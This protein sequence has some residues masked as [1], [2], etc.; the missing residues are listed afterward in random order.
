MLGVFGRVAGAL[1][2]FKWGWGPDGGFVSFVSH[3]SGIVCRFWRPNGFSKQ[4]C[5]RSIPLMIF[6][7]ID[8]IGHHPGPLAFWSE[9]QECG[10]IYTSQ[11]NHFSAWSFIPLF[12][13][14]A[15]F[16]CFTDPFLAHPWIFFSIIVSLATETDVQW[17]EHQTLK[18]GGKIQV[19]T[20][21]SN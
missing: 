11:I 9:T 5:G 12:Y 4:A 21:N 7:A 1:L 19:Q 2:E 13:S 16:L 3:R 18:C 14:S 20:C 15:V 17:V 10:H 6:I 8:C